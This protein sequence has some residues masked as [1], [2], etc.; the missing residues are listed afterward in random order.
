MRHPAIQVSAHA[1]QMA[2]EL[3]HRNDDLEQAA[4]WLKA[5]AHPMRLKLLCAIGDDEFG[6]RE[7]LSLVGTTPSNVSLHLGVLLSSGLVSRRRRGNCHLYRVRYGRTMELIHAAREVFCSRR[8][9][10]N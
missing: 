4:G 9:R 1:T 6:I 5:M 10:H 2:R 3:A 7:L 8:T